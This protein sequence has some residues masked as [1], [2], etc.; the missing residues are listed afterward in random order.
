MTDLTIATDDAAKRAG[1]TP[2]KRVAIDA[3]PTCLLC[4]A[5][6]RRSDVDGPMVHLL[7]TGHLTTLREHP[8]S[9][10]LHAIGRTCARK[11]RKIDARLVF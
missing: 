5:A 10:G 3:D 2:A 11:L 1:I 9:Q 4:G 8:E 6:I 7:W